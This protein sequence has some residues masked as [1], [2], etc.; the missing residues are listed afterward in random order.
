L[1]TLLLLSYQSFAQIDTAIGVHT[2]K[3]EAGSYKK[4]AHALCDTLPSDRQK[5]NAIYNWV[6]HHIRYDVKAMQQGRLKEEKPE[7]VFKQ[8]K[9]M[10]AGYSLLFAAMCHE[11][12]L[13][14]VTIDGYAKDWMF[15]DGDKL[16]IP[17]HAWNAVYIDKKWQ[18]V[19]ATWGAGG[20]S[21]APGWLKQQI[22]K[23]AKDPIQASGKLRFRYQYDTAYFLADPLTFRIRHLPSDP[24]WQLTDTCLPLQVF[25]AGEAA[26]RNFN[27]RYSILVENLPELD[28]MAAMDE[29]ARIQ[30]SATRVSRYNPRFHVIMAARHQ[31]DAVDT[32]TTY[33][34]GYNR[35][36][37]DGALATIK[38][39][40]KNAE[41]EVNAQKGSITA[42]YAQLKTKNKTK[43]R[44]AQ[45][46]I[47]SIHADNKR[48]IAQCESRV[49]NGTARTATV[50]E[51][52]AAA[53]RADRNTDAGKLAS[54]K[55]AARPEPVT[56][57]ALRALED[58]VAV[59]DSRIAVL[60][61]EITLQEERVKK[62][63]EANG[64]RLDTLAA[65]FQLADSA[66]TEETIARIRM[67]DNYD[68]EVLQWNRIVQT[69]RLQQ[70]DS[71]QK[72]Y[73]A[74]YDSVTRGYEALRKLQ[75]AQL[76]QYRKNFKDIEQYKRSNN[77]N[78][79]LFGRYTA[80]MQEHDTCMAAY[81]RTLGSYAGYIQG[82]KKLFGQLVKLYKRQEKLAG[83]MEKSEQKRKELEQKNLS[84]KEAFDKKENEQQKEQLKQTGR[85]AEK[86]LARQ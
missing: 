1:V 5:A 70:V 40:L 28:Q 55:T 21:Q 16:Y 26:I 80:Q 17:R 41:Q 30:A 9:G 51:K 45:Q 33:H 73:F 42:E 67:H 31:A 37:S 60:K 75:W 32:L 46:Y 68:E 23:A 19:D 11:A 53:A 27:A 50:K 76:E 7:K 69:A 47:R 79:T 83:Y 18:L 6:T 20:I 74:G 4:L 44:L 62:L 63:R 22:S 25:E 15:D 38:Q 58:S 57:P 39:R 29:R 61:Q 78:N 52:A 66:L 43:S 36:S 59:R 71:V 54:V 34:N 72:Y 49:R 65:I 12:G 85:K 84:E 35:G 82:N 64:D 14:A 81:Y 86:L 48:M 56:A 8:R 24:L 77:T 2:P 3:G 13:K 10:C